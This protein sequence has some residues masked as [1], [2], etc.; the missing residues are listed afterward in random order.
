MPGSPVTKTIWRVPRHAASMP[1]WSRSSAD[2]RP[3]R[4]A[5][6]RY[7][8]PLVGPNPTGD[9]GRPVSLRPG[10]GVGDA[11]D[12][13]ISAAVNR[14]HEARRADPIAER[15]ADLAHADLE[16]RIAHGGP[17]PHALEQDILRDELAVALDETL[18]H[19][20]GLRRQADCLRPPPQTRIVQI[21][22]KRREAK[23]PRRPHIHYH[24]L[25]QL[26]PRDYDPAIAPPSA[27]SAMTDPSRRDTTIGRATDVAQ[28]PVRRA[29]VVQFP[30]G[31]KP[32]SAARSRGARLVLSFFEGTTQ[33]R[34]VS[35]DAAQS[36]KHGLIVKVIF[37]VAALGSG[38]DQG[39]THSQPVRR[40]KRQ[41]H[42]AHSRRLRS[43]RITG[44]PFHLT[45]NSEED[46]MQKT[47]YVFPVRRYGGGAGRSR[48]SLRRSF[49]LQRRRSGRADGHGVSA[50]ESRQDRNR[51][52]RR[53]ILAAET[54]LD[55]ARLT[56][57]IFTRG[58]W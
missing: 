51:G 56:G 58:P 11:G 39:H 33:G 41:T 2:S 24:R 20:K 52:R 3:T 43:G 35:G 29:F 9:L 49:L 38:G 10:V 15:L 1:L 54:H 32:A 16:Y 13:S 50:R 37:G 48:S 57:L 19:G 6:P 30:A 21:E 42:R 28:L 40:I 44:S 17:R 23:L 12:E 34:A 26:L 8:E 22:P 14:R 5:G 45:T 47:R 25:T 55:R 53:L 4:W 7:R 46:V 27:D 18:Q 31:G 36:K